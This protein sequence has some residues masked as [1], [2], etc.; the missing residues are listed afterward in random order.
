MSIRFRLIITYLCLSIAPLLIVIAIGLYWAQGIIV[1]EQLSHLRAMTNLKAASVEGYYSDLKVDIGIAQDYFNVIHNLPILY[2]QE[3]NPTSTDFQAA[4]AMLDGQMQRWLVERKDI[5]NFLLV[6]PDGHI[7]YSASSTLRD[8]IMF[9]GLSDPGNLTFIGAHDGVSISDLFADPESTGNNVFLVAAPI[10]TADNSFIGEVILEI[11]ARKV[12]SLINDATGLGST[13]ETLLVKII[14]NSDSSAPNKIL[15]LNPLKFDS[16]AALNKTINVGDSSGLPAQSAATGNNGEGLSTDYRGKQVYAVWR[17]L[18]I[19]GMGMVTKIDESEIHAPIYILFFEISIVL[20]ILLFLFMGIIPIMVLLF[21]SP[22]RQLISVTQQIARGDLSVKISDRLLDS[23]NEFGKLATFFDVMAKKLKESYSDLEKKVRE[24][25]RSLEESKIKDEA[26]LSSIGDGIIAIDAKGKIVLMNKAAEKMIGWKLSEAEGKT[27]D[28]IVPLVDEK[29]V[30]LP[31]QKRPRTAVF[32]RG[33][34]IKTED[35]YYVRKDKTI[36]PVAITAAPVI[37]KGKVIGVIDAFRDVTQERLVDRAKTEFVSLA[38]H[39]L[40]TPLSAINWYSEML[41]AGDAGKLNKTQA[42][43]VN[44]VY[45]GNQRMVD[46]VNALL[47]ISRIDLGT[48]AVDPEPTDFCEVAKSVLAESKPMIATKKM[49]AS[50]ECEKGLPKVNADPKLIR[51]VFQNLLTNALKYTPDKGKVVVSVAK[52]DKNVLIKVTDNGYGIPESSKDKIF[53]KLY[54][55]DN[56]REHDT[57]GTGLGLYMVKAIVEDSGGK[58][59][60]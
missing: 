15:Y 26:M 10:I 46:L 60:F 41:L 57:E 31:V 48:F 5:Q 47:N 44:Q 11:N 39:Q 20:I 7:V 9:K 38:S 1:N 53:T 32:T 3:A 22:I 23:K 52:Q 4:T 55:A 45:A 59:W 21:T 51:I 30:K 33:T 50:C 13:G 25:T 34:V 35:Y 12:Y 17:Y 14:P 37:V 40:R 28:D 6:A 16:K 2:R 58:V 8:K 43:Y 19:T 56:I 29:G 18:P 42:D 24:R 27:L 36:F 54:R 49:D